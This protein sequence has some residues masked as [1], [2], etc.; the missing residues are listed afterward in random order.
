VTSHDYHAVLTF[1]PLPPYSTT[2]IRLQRG[3]LRISHTP[4]TATTR[5]PA[6]RKPLELA[7]QQ[8]DAR[9]SGEAPG[10]AERQPEWPT[11]QA[12]QP[13]TC[14]SDPSLRAHIAPGKRTHHRLMIPLSRAANRS[15]A[16][17]PS[18]RINPYQDWEALRWLREQPAHKPRAYR[19]LARPHQHSN[20]LGR[21]QR[22]RTANPA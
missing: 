6:T 15:A 9:S 22:A 18:T 7:D 3:C 13:E 19:G 2:L 14:G 12:D 17:A 1:C 5:P 20:P 10:A 11:E 4:A 8:T 16:K 21:I